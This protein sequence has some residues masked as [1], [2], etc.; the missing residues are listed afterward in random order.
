MNIVH[1]H[2]RRIEEIPVFRKFF[3]ET[4]RLYTPYIYEYLAQKLDI[5]PRE[6][7]NIDDI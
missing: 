2:R 1:G 5:E 4:C 3:H 6:R 7:I